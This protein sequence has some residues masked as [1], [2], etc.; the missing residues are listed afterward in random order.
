MLQKKNLYC[1]CMASEAKHCTSC[2]S[3]HCDDLVKVTAIGISCS[4]NAVPFRSSF[5]FFTSNWFRLKSLN[6]E[7]WV[8]GNQDV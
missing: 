6:Q 5:I 8:D 2:N 7:I 4:H 3:F 1:Q